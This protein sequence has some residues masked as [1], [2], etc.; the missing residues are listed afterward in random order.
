V[1]DA[2][3]PAAHAATLFARLG[4]ILPLAFAFCLALGAIAVRRKAR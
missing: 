3:L 4:N 1:I 2:R